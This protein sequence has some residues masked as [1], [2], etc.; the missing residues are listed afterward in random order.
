M[1][2]ILMKEHLLLDWKH[3]LATADLVMF[4]FVSFRG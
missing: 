3:A 2:S 4:H 1:F